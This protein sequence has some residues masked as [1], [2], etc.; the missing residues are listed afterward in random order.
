MHCNY[1]RPTRSR[2]TNSGRTM[3]PAAVTGEFSAADREAES[4][5]ALAPVPGGDGDGGGNR[6]DRVLSGRLGGLGAERLAGPALPAIA[7]PM[8]VTRG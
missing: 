5:Q 6:A 4:I 3:I 7:V 1:R 8:A 2:G